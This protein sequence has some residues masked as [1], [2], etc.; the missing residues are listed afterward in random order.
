ME[1]LG[2]GMLQAVHDSNLI[3]TEGLG[4]SKCVG[5]IRANNV[6]MHI[7]INIKQTQSECP[8]IWI[9]ELYHDSLMNIKMKM[10]LDN[11]LAGITFMENII[12][13]EHDVAI[14]DGNLHL[15]TS[16]HDSFINIESK[17]PFD[18]KFPYFIQI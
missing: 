17:M 7:C 16:P 3:I 8:E 18:K 13:A 10:P 6:F 14:Q 5:Y 2:S 12:K 4:I 1:H 9:G 15:W 11:I